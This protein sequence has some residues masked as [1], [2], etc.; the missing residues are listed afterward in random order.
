ML[1]AERLLRRIPDPSA[2]QSKGVRLSLYPGSTALSPHLLIHTSS[3]GYVGQLDG[4]LSSGISRA[5][6][7]NGGFGHE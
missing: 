4:H 6:Y 5:E 2:E 3:S 7:R 1:R